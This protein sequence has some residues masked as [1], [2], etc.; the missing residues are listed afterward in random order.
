MIYFVIL[1][2]L[3]WVALNLTSSRKLH[4][5]VQPVQLLLATGTV[6]YSLVLH[7]FLQ[8]LQSAVSPIPIC[9]YSVFVNLLVQHSNFIRRNL[10]Y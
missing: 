7:Q 9:C 6:H 10:R 1:Q 8:F 3:N 5:S 2:D 4:S